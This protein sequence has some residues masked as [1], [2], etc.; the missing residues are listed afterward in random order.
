M[1]KIIQIAKLELSLLFYSPVAWLLIMIFFVQM[2]H[3]FVPSLASMQ[4]LQQLL[5]DNEFVTDRLFATS[6]GSSFGILYIILGSLY[7][8]TPLITMG[9]ISR[10]I[11]S[12]SIKLLYSSPVK[13]TQIIYGKFAAMLVYNL[14]IVGIAGLFFILG[15]CVV[16]HFDFPHVLVAML[17]CFLLLSAYAAIGIFMSSLTSYQ[18]VAALGTFGLLAFMNYIGNFGQGIDFVRDLTHSLSM[19]SRAERMVHGLLNTRDVIYYMVIS[20]I[21]LALTIARLELMRSSKPFLYQMGRYLLI[22]I[23]GIAAAYLSSRQAVIL[24]YDATA[25]KVNTIVKPVQEVL[26]KM[27]DEPVEVTAYINGIHQTY[28]IGA[29]VQRLYGISKWEPYLRFKGNIHLHWVYYYDILDP[30]FYAANPGKSIKTVFKEYAKTQDIDTGRFLSPEQIRKQVDLRGENDRMLMQLKYK[31]KT[32]FLRT[33]DD[34][35]RWP[36]EAEI[37]AALKRLVV[38]PPKIVFATDAYQRRVDKIGDRDY[39]LFFNNKL[40]RSSLVNMGFDLD[41]VSLEHG[42]I[43]KDIAVLVIGDP[44]AALNP[45]ALDHLQN[46]IKQGGNVLIA[47]EPG[48]QAVINP[49]LDSLGVEM[50]SGTLVQRSNDYSY[51]LITPN[52]TSAA[53]KMSPALKKPY[54]DEAVISMSGAAALKDKHQ[55]TFKVDPILMT[56]PKTSWI[57][58]GSFVLDSAALLFDAKIGDEKGAFPTALM[59]TRNVNHKEQRIMVAGD[60]DFFSNRELTRNNLETANGSLAVSIFSWFSNSVFPIDTS[61]PSSMDKHLKLSKAGVKTIKVLYYAVIPTTII[62]L[63]MVLLI[64]RKR[65]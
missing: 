10:E 12:G 24:Y 21:F 56:N 33:F 59:L 6:T 15:A 46:Y 9:L 55:G 27:Q 2:T 61:R 17:A 3:S 8:Y 39:Q 50:R 53:V 58:K 34:G 13:I 22:F 18:I 31:G 16:D 40:S 14:V 42:T 23:S 54:Q 52:L 47:G 48:K 5:G 51:G 62:L 43:P 36:G 7:L 60:A 25:T 49:L 44:R 20:A 57:K 30:Q 26:K 37:A 19:P 1:K 63:G 41:S 4:H 65:K 38:T 64:R 45:A 28:S 11:S 35:D 29:P 32:T